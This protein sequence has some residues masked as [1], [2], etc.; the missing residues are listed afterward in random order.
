[1]F[2]HE[3]F[4]KNT[5]TYDATLAQSFQRAINKR[6]RLHFNRRF[7][8]CSPKTGEEFAAC[9]QGNTIKETPRR[10]IITL[11][12]FTI[13]YIGVFRPVVRSLIPGTTSTTGMRII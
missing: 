12:L 7:R 6:H 11:S 2:Y 4:L 1:M 5:Y 13:L 9:L 3:R 10:E 8:L